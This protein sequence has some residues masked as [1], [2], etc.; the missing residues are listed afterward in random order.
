AGQ[1]EMW[2]GE[3]APIQAMREVL[4]KKIEGN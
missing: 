1:F 4:M 3:K 2:T